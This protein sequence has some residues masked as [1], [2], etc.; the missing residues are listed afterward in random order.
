V[1]E[2]KSYE[3]FG[4]LDPSPFML[5]TFNVMSDK[6]LT[7]PAVTHI[8]GTAR[9]QTV[10]KESNPV[11]WRLIREF[12]KLTGVPVL[13]NTSFNVQEPIV[14]TPHEAIDC[15]MRTKADYLVLNTLLIERPT[16]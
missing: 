13:L 5:F 4:N 7:I 3:Y 8:D 6:K 15:F 16:V 14:C 10:S 1:L 11:Y 2:E 9:P 12:D